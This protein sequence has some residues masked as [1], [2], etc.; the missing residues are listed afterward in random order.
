MDKIRYDVCR[1]NLLDFKNRNVERIHSGVMLQ[2][3]FYL[4]HPDYESQA[5]PEELRQEFFEDIRQC[6]QVHPK[7]I[8]P[9]LAVMSVRYLPAQSCPVLFC[10]FYAPSE[11]LQD[12]IQN[13]T[14]AFYGCAESSNVRI[15]KTSFDSTDFVCCN[16]AYYLD[17]FT[18]NSA[19][20]KM[21]ML[22]ELLQNSEDAGRLTIGTYRGNTIITTSDTMDAV[23]AYSGEMRRNMIY[24]QTDLLD[25]NT[26]MTALNRFRMNCILKNYHHVMNT[27]F[28]CEQLEILSDAQKEIQ[29]SPELQRLFSKAPHLKIQAKAFLASAR[30]IRTLFQVP[31]SDRD[32]ERIL[33]NNFHLCQQAGLALDI[34]CLGSDQ[35]IS[36]YEC[37]K[38]RQMP[39]VPGTRN[40]IAAELQIPVEWFSQTLGWALFK[41]RQTAVWPIEGA[42]SERAKLR[43]LCKKGLLKMERRKP[44]ISRQ[45]FDASDEMTEHDCYTLYLIDG[46]ITAY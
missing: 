36:F 24:F 15:L 2:D 35:N 21:Q 12:F 4:S 31:V 44:H 32:V 16:K 29:Y 46:D 6:V 39:P 45:V 42:A 40:W 37:C 26:D 5:V 9:L 3:A 38:V 8:Y 17:R 33:I 28:S 7:L 34:N 43:A 20:E 23:L 11:E 1:K 27:G 41:A 14:A 18:F 10:H 30:V 19:A 13:L 22:E 25:G